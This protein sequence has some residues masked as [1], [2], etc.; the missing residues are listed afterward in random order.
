MG[1][2]CRCDSDTFYI[3]LAHQDIHKEIF[4]KFDKKMYELSGISGISVR[5]GIYEHCDKTLSVDELIDRA[6]TACNTCRVNLHQPLQ[7]T[8][9]N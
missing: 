7:C 5:M 2:G 3:Y 1:L 9:R 4:E 6:A 8:T